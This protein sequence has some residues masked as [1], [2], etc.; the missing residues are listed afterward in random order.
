MKLSHVL[1]ITF[2][3]V[4]STQAQGEF[5]DVAAAAAPTPR[6]NKITEWIFPKQINCTLQ[7]LSDDSLASRQIG[8]STILR[9]LQNKANNN[10]CVENTGKKEKGTQDC[11]LT[12]TPETRPGDPKQG[13]N[14]LYINYRLWGK[15]PT[16]TKFLF[17]NGNIEQVSRR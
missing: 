17:K 10:H 11:T 15:E 6:F 3:L 5:D 7:A 13:W 2:S 14:E 8:S 4:T 9:A 12:F 16:A 1:I